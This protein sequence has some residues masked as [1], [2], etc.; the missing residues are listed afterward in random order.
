MFCECVNNASNSKK[1]TPFSFIYFIRHVQDSSDVWKDQLI[2]WRVDLIYP[3]ITL[4]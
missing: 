4:F 1:L 3:K 2:R